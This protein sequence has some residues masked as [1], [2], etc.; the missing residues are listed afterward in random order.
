[1]FKILVAEDDAEL[2]ELFCTVLNENGYQALGA[3]NGTEA[4]D[5]LE[6]EYID[7]LVTDV[8]MPHMDGYELIRQLREA[9]YS[10]PILVITA[11]S[12]ISDKKK[13][14]HAGTDDY[15]VKPVDVNEM[16]WRI[17]ALLRR[18]QAVNARRLQIGQTYFD[19]D[20]LTVTR[21]KDVQ[22]L[23]QKE[24]FL[25]CKLVS[26]A[27]KV[28]TKRQLFDEIWGLDSETDPHTLEVHI[29]RLRERF[30][31]NP[32]FEIATIRGLGYKAIET[33]APLP[34]EEFHEK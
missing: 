29:S 7:L 6:R 28:F 30:K 27:G 15:M 20:S 26:S 4:L 23:P 22:L 17:A 5:I 34:E 24:F 8:M 25:L 1:M 12:A 33:D 21:Q 11:K 32:D 19:C 3:G 14:F 13:G 9:N 31:E 10:L 16:L 2:R 18:S